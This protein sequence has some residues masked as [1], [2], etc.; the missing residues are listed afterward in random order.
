MDKRSVSTTPNRTSELFTWW[1]STN[2][3]STFH[4]LWASLAESEVNS[5]TSRLGKAAPS[6]CAMSGSIFHRNLREWN[7][8]F[9]Q[10]AERHGKL[11]GYVSSPDDIRPVFHICSTQQR[12]APPCAEIGRASC[13]RRIKLGGRG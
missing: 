6:L 13:G 8:L 3:L 5:T 4:L 11:T 12:C 7:S 2:A 10:T 1:I 9:H